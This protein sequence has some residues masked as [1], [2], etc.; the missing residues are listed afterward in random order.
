ML[1]THV[2]WTKNSHGPGKN[3]DTRKLLEDIGGG[4]WIIT[5]CC[6]ANLRPPP[7]LAPHSILKTTQDSILW[8]VLSIILNQKNFCNFIK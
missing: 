2:L 4:I 6:H 7:S 3:H 5:S 8:R 1:N